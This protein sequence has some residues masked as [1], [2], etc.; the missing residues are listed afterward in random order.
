MLPNFI[1]AGTEKS[2]TSSLVFY[3][4]EHSS[5]Y[6]PSIKEIYFF[7]NE[8]N[9]N[10]GIEWYEKWF[11]GWSGEKAVGEC[12]PLYMYDPIC[13]KKIADLFPEIKLIFILRNPVDRAYSNYW[14]QV[15]AGREFQPFEE[16]L[17]KSR[18]RIIKNK[19]NSR[20]Y[21]YLDK[22]FYYIQLR[23]FMDRFSR[24]QIHV[25][26]F[27]DLIKYSEETLNRIYSFL[28]VEPKKKHRSIN[29]IKNKTK[30][31][32]SRYIQYAAR[33]VFGIS[34]IF[35]AISR[36]NI[37]LGFEDYP[38]M[39]TKTKKYLINYFTED[40]N[41]LEALTGINFSLWKEHH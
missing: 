5:I 33:K 4:R 39:T 34:F 2:G 19:Y 27:D 14:H 37:N 36:I 17:K 30:L 20:H 28:E 35:K 10:K 12:T 23:R 7:N 15:R 38:P 24:E 18:N 8:S 11:S 13:S 32:R 26:K 16:S 1:I 40:I 29:T 21:S 41:R 9:F 6:I 3:L 31:P 22:G 25:I